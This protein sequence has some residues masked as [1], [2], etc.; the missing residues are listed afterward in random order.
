MKNIYKVKGNI[1]ITSDE[2]I[3]DCYVLTDLDKIIKVDES[4]EEQWHEF[5]CKK[6]I[7]ITDEQ[8]IKDGVQSIDKPFLVWLINNPNCEEVQVY[9]DLIE[10]EFE[11]HSP[12]KKYIIIIPKEKHKRKI[13][14]CYNFNKEIGCVQLDCRCEK[15][16]SKFEKSIENTI[17]F[18]NIAN[19]M[20]SKK[21]EPKQ[22]TSEEEPKQGIDIQEFEKKANEIIANVGKKETIEQAAKEYE[23]SFKDADG[24]E[25][26][27]FIAGAKWQQE[28]SYN[29]EEMLDILNSFAKHIII[30]KNDDSTIAQWFEF[31]KK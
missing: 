8:L 14:T 18:M 21:E 1:I 9:Y 19:A 12:R 6:I 2:E 3:K 22:Y 30:N 10:F 13:D 16:E 31:K 25:S 26:V 28:R 4:N 24:T 29:E 7:L 27:D 23:N 11:K 5:N 17:N 20:F 15:E